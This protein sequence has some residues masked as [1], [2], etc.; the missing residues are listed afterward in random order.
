MQL[1]LGASLTASQLGLPLEG[2]NYAEKAEE[3]VQV[4]EVLM[5]EN[6]L[7]EAFNERHRDVAGEGEAGAGLAGLEDDEEGDAPADEAVEGEGGLNIQDKVL[8]AICEAEELK[9]D[10][11]AVR[12]K[13]AD[14]ILDLKAL[15]L[16]A[17]RQ[18]SE[19]RRWL[20]SF[21]R[22]VL[23]DTQAAV[24]S[25]KELDVDLSSDPALTRALGAA[26]VAIG[27]PESGAL[28]GSAAGG[29]GTPGGASRS[30]SPARDGGS[31]GVPA[32]SAAPQAAPGAVIQVREFEI[33]DS[34][35][36]HRIASFYAE[37]ERLLT[38]QIEGLR[39]KIYEKQREFNR[40][41]GALQKSSAGRSEVS[42]I[43][44]DQMS[45]EN[46][47]YLE[48]ISAKNQELLRL[49]L[50]AGNT[51]VVLNN[52]KGELAKI[53]EEKLF[54][55]REIQAKRAAIERLTAQIA[56]NKK[57]MAEDKAALKRLRQNEIAAGD[58]PFSVDYISLN[59]TEVSLEK[60]LHE[61][62]RKIFI[63]EKRYEKLSRELSVRARASA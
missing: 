18:L 11:E 58:G 39:K 49:K 6:L 37:M 55:E 60:A 48:K 57:G 3:V 47:K 14:I 34:V 35:Q 50:T 10:I 63:L 46:G 56:E 23:R 32:D 51:G 27:S 1:N 8:V 17:E 28:A 61:Y 42:S 21:R 7:L 38:S 36:S 52:F 24:H 53:Q 13:G 41:A 31:L 54:V 12:A 26:G 15:T 2:V 33:P 9:Q 25:G 59:A 16:S 29:R 45:I 44:F 43:D 19:R 20:F 62:E 5:K 40:R 4:N 30:P 22:D